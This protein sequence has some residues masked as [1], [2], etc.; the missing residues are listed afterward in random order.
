MVNTFADIIGNDRVKSYLTRMME[1]E[2]IAQSMLFA[3]P[4]GVGKSLFAEY[5]ARLVLD[6]EKQHHPDLHIYRPQGKIGM[7]SIGSMRQF[8]R[9]VYMAPFQAKRKVFIIHDAHRMLSYSANALLKTFEEPSLASV[10]I[11]LSSS[12]EQLLPTILSRCQK[13]RFFPI[14]HSD[15]VRFIQTRKDVP[16]D[17]ASAI[18]YRARGSIG[19][20]VR[21][22]EQENDPTRE[23]LLQ[24]LASGLLRSYSGVQQVVKEINEQVTILLKG[25]EEAI[26]SQLFQ[27]FAEDLPAVQKHE[28]EKEVEGY[29]TMQRVVEAS[30]LFD[31]ILS[32][33]RDLQ[34]LHVNGNKNLLMNPDYETELTQA[35]QRGKLIPLEQLQ[36]AISEAKLALQRSTPLEYCLENLLLKI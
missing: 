22:L 16:S 26:R 14:E 13:I 33:A 11:L 15:L 7:H 21:I 2:K 17:K 4:D 18:A 10:I 9:E 12:P 32:W 29:L 25:G 3:G 5:F 6:T 1:K 24:S 19:Q 34:L 27:D 36:E 31:I 28:I 23:I 30:A 35:L 20:A 8:S